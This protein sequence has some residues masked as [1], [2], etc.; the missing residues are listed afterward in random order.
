MRQWDADHLPDDLRDV[1]GW[2]RAEK[3]EVSPFEL[4]RIKL[5]AMSRARPPNVSK[6]GKGFPVMRTKLVTMLLV[7]GLAVSGGAAGVIAGKG[8][9]GNGSAAKSEYRPGKGCG[10]KNH[11]HTGPPGNPSNGPETCPQQAGGKNK[12]NGQKSK[13]KNK[14]K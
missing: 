3:P 9:G 11:T 10:D 13:G 5:R 1:E 8:G 2:L 7:L 6:K 12:S 4:D 14:K